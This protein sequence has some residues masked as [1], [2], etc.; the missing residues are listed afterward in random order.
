[1]KVVRLSSLRTCRIYPQEISLVL[2]RPQGH[3]AA[4]TIK[5]MRNPDDPTGNR[6]R[7]FPACST[8]PQPTAPP[9]LI[10][11][12]YSQHILDKVWKNTRPVK[13]AGILC[14]TPHGFFTK[15]RPTSKV[16]SL[17]FLTAHSFQ[18]DILTNTHTDAAAIEVGRRDSRAWRAIS[19]INYGTKQLTEWLTD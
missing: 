8:V 9:W 18:K 17:C 16:D 19:L 4:G 7:D 11:R 13:T 6:T 3:S 5:S 14:G 15:R 10:S 1:M 12:Y 2:S